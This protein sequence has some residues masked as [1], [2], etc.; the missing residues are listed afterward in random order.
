[1]KVNADSSEKPNAVP[2]KANSPSERS[3]A[4]VTIVHGSVRLVSRLLREVVRERSEGALAG[5]WGAG[6][7]GGQPLYPLL[8]SVE[9][10]LIFDTC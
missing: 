9:A 4:G 8:I 1:V 7:R 5:I 10:R 6:E 2:L 3:D